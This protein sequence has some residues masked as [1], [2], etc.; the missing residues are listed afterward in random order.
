M[1]IKG[2]DL[3]IVRPGAYAAASRM[4]SPSMSTDVESNFESPM[5]PRS[6]GGGKKGPIRKVTGIK[7]EFKTEAERDGFVSVAKRMQGKS[8]PL[9]E[10]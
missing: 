7:I 9:P 1:R 4:R 3:K 10:L 5:S 8:T 6:P 2:I